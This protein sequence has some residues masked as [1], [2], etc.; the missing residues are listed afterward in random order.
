MALDVPVMPV[1][2][3]QPIQAVPNLPAAASSYMPDARTAPS[4]RCKVVGGEVL[5]LDHATQNFSQ[6]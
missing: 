4:M 6:F 5:I 3:R 1:S 2:T